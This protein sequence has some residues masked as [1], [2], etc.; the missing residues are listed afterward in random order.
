M[1][2]VLLVAVA[3]LGLAAFAPSNERFVLDAAATEIR[4]EGFSLRG[5]HEGTLRAARGVLQ[6]GAGGRL[7]GGEVV[8]PLGSL[9]VTDVTED[10]PRRRLRDHLL[11]EDFFWAAR[12]PTARLVVTGAVGKGIG[13]KRVTANL[14]MRGVT[15]PVTFD[16]TERRRPDGGIEVR[17]R[18]NLDRQRWGVRFTRSRE[19]LVRD[20]FTLDVRLVVN[21]RE[22]L[23]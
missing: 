14:T 20:V 1:M 22:P 12:Y 18:L 9:A 6:Y 8:V 4:W 21:P 23:R 10:G 13:Q 3:A 19:L 15:L 2:R 17:A 16:A 11:A 7:L 5:S